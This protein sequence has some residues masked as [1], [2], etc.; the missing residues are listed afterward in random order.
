MHRANGFS[1]LELLT[2][3]AVIGILAAVGINY[4]NDYAIR[5]KLPEATSALSDGRIK[6]EQFFQDNRT[7]VGGPA[8]TATKYF[9]YAVSG[10]SASAYTISAQGTGSMSEWTLT[11]NQNNVRQTT[12][13][14]ADYAAASMPASCWISR[15]KGSC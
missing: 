13:A 6:M 9:T 12:A 10:A 5:A 7:Y 2:V 1:L 3:V 4:Y 8:P 14:P 15:K 11:I